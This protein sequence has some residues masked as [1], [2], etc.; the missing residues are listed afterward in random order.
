M[1]DLRQRVLAACASGRPVLIVIAGSNGAGKSTYYNEALATLGLPFVNADEI[2]RARTGS[3]AGST[4]SAIAYEAMH[5]AEAQRQQL[6]ESHESFVMETVLSDRGGAKLEFFRS[7]VGA[8]YFCVFVYIRLVDAELSVARVMQRVAA[9]GHDVPDEK[10]LA[11]FPRTQANAEQ[12]LRIA[13]FGLVLDNSSLDEPYRW[14][15]TW[16]NGSCVERTST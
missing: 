2:A 1:T 14:N 7:A 12:A 6:L 5:A 8:G 10:L 13:N 9:G 3:W 16:E 15:E 4:D 11:R